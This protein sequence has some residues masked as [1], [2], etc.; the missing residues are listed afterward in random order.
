M[1]RGTIDKRV[2]IEENIFPIFPTVGEKQIKEKESVMNG[3]LTIKADS[4]RVGGSRIFIGDQEFGVTDI[5]IS[6]NIRDDVWKVDMSIYVKSL[7]IEL[8]EGY[9]LQTTDENGNDYEIVNKKGEI[10]K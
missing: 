4:P 1:M 10:I 5:T 3:K 9:V 2:N 7:D 6:G 8:A